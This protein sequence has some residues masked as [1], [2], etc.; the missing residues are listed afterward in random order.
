MA[1][2]GAEAERL[3]GRALDRELVAGVERFKPGQH[4]ATIVA[5]DVT[6]FHDPA[7]RG[8]IGRMTFVDL[9]GHLCVILAWRETGSVY[10]KATWI[11]RAGMLA[12][13]PV[14]P[15]PDGYELSEDLLAALRDADGRAGRQSSAGSHCLCCV[16][17]TVSAE[18]DWTYWQRD[19][20]A[21]WRPQLP[22][23]GDPMARCPACGWEHTD[24]DDG[25]GVYQGTLE[26][27]EAQR[28]AD[29][30]EQ[31][32]WWA[33]RLADAETSPRPEGPSS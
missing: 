30:P 5:R 2:P 17:G 12:S 19:D 18:A 20:E 25:S 1:E 15:A 22:G 3:A 8:D 28:A 14:L 29:L 10:W 16:C 11:G 6:N 33:E 4:H 24:L 9:T 21:E 23:E 13:E 32:E 27:M 31:G 7:V 26:Q